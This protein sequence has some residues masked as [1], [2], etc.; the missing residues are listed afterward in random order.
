M[1]VAEA[2][3][4]RRSIRSYQ[5]V[6]IEKEKI[7]KILQAAQLAP[8]A[9][10]Y[11]NWRFVMVRNKE[12]IKKL[13]VI[14]ANQSFI[15]DVDTV[16]CCCGTKPDHVMSGGEK[17]YCVDV[18]IAM[19]FMM[20]QATELGIGTC[21]IGAYNQAKVKTLLRIPDD[22]RVASLLTFGYP[23]FTPAPTD[24]KPLAE[25]IAVEHYLQPYQ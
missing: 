10:N 17:S 8:S 24:R 18:S 2:I 19:S 9:G 22:V 11:Q 6:P 12:T 7:E 13:A 4:T 1:D 5:N 25:I 23:H 20:L 3:K 14:C 16:I 15:A 21:C